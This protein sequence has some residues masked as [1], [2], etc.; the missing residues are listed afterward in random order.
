MHMTQRDAFTALISFGL[1]G[2]LTIALT[3]NSP[4]QDAENIICLSNMKHLGLGILMYSQDYDATLPPLSDVSNF[5]KVMLPY[6]KKKEFFLCPAS[7]KPYVL[8]RKFIA[9]YIPK[10]Y[11]LSLASIPTPA[12][13]V[14]MY[15]AK[16]HADK[17][18]CVTYLDGHAKREKRL[19]PLGL[20]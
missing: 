13:T 5:Q 6:V 9:S 4:R 18:V 10:P 19:P 15:D 11:S 7:K 2:I 20:R 8:N 14:I 3:Q 17:S 12:K 1:I 16:P